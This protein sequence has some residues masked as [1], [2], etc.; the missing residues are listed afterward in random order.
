MGYND[1][2]DACSKEFPALLVEFRTSK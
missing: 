1:A 2:F